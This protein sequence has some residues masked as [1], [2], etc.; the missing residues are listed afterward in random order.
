MFVTL[1]LIETLVR[2]V[3]LLKIE[4]PRT[5]TLAGITKLVRLVQKENVEFPRLVMELCNVTTRNNRHPANVLSPMLATLLGI[6]TLVRL[7]HAT[8]VELPRLVMESGSITTLSNWHPA[9]ALLPM[10]VTLLGIV[11]LVSL[12]GPSELSA[13]APV[14]MAITGSPLVEHHTVSP[15]VFGYGNRAVVDRESEL[16]LHC[17]WPP[18]EREHR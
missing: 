6:V 5:R 18:Q 17:R 11:T 1:L 16:R 2:L 7:M 4:F 9:N 12:H 3:Q 13:N 15:G 8:N 10:L 14:P